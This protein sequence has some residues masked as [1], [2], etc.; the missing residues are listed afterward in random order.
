MIR[1]SFVIRTIGLGLFL[2]G[3]IAC[4]GDNP[5]PK[6]PE[7]TPAADTSETTTTPPAAE[8]ADS[9]APSTATTAEPPP[10]PAALA[11]PS[12]AAKVKAK[13][14]KDFDVELKSDGTVSSAGKPV[15]KI[16]GMELQ[17]KDGKAQLKVDHDGN[18]TTADG[19]P[20]AK[21][22]GD[23]LVTSTGAK[24]TIADDGTF[25][26]TP[27]KGAEKSVGKATDVGAAKKAA[28]LSIAFVTWGTKAPQAKA[29]A[30][31]AEKKPA[32]KKPAKK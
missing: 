25:K 22:E 4:G 7:T 5:P 1:S 21:F 8:P 16:T 11:L 17:D 14:T 6:P 30:K 10:A 26:A 19:S 31:P 9:G 12:A 15:A 28:L 2:A 18:I 24:W 29:A 32:E 27:E 13:T 3:N 20:Y 23:T